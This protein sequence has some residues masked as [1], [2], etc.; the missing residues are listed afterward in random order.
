M[1]LVRITKRPDGG[2]VLHCV[3]GDGSETWQKQASR[4]AA[5][6]ALHDLTHFAVETALGFKRGFFGLI[7]EGWDVEDTTGKGS[8]GALPEEAA[9]VEYLVGAFDSERAGG[10]LWTAAEFNE[11]SGMQAASS[12]RKPPRRLVDSDLSRVRDLRA[13][14]FSDWSALAP[15][16][17]M[18]LR[19]GPEAGSEDRLPKRE[20]PARRRPA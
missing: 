16:A 1:L 2:G 7:A 15:G 13:R 6:F 14:L 8:R 11:Y 19:F 20:T 4:H 12:G 9:E 5:F 3:R 17:A 18:E 10:A